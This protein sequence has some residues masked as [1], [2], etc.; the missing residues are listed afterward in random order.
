VLP[1]QVDPYT[2]EAKSVAPL[3]WS[4]AAYVHAVHSVARRLNAFS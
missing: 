2:G 4:H 3:T 1:E